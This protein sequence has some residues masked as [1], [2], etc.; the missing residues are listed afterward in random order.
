MCGAI[1]VT[2]CLIEVHFAE[3][4]RIWNDDSFFGTTRAL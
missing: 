3:L 4:S 2:D 1:I